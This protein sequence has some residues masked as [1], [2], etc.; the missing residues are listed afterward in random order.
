MELTLHKL[1]EG[2][3]VTSD[4]KYEEGKKYNSFVYNEGI[5]FETNRL[6]PQFKQVIAQQDQI[7]FSDLKEEEQK[8][9][10]F[11]DVEMFALECYPI[12]QFEDEFDYRFR[13]GFKSGFRKAL[14]LT[15]GIR[16]T[17]EDIARAFLKGCQSERMLSNRGKDLK[18]YIQSLSQLK[19]WKVEGHIENDK[20]KITKIL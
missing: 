17:E 3:I 2:F 1:P 16:F 6:L 5:V 20:F 19:S 15:S 11:F 10:G 7:D 4:E 12:N 14:E 8:R 18:N 13:F 9:I